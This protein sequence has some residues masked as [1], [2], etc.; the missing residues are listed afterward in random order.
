MATLESLRR[1]VYDA[2]EDWN[3][4][5]DPLLINQLLNRAQNVFSRDSGYL[6]GVNVQN[7]VAGTAL[8]TLTPPSNYRIGRVDAVQFHDGNGAI[9]SISVS[10]GGSLYTSSPT[11]TIAAPT[12]GTTATA[13][14]TASGGAV[15]A[16][17]L[18][19]AGTGYVGAPAISFS[20]G[21]GSGATAWATMAGIDDVPLI[22]LTLAEMNNLDSNWRVRTGQR[23]SYYLRNYDDATA[24]TARNESFRLYPLP[25]TNYTVG[26]RVS[27]RL[28][29]AGQMTT[30]STVMAL[31]ERI[32]EDAL[33]NYAAGQILK[34]MSL[35]DPRRSRFLT[36]ESDRYMALWLKDLQEA[37]AEVQT[38]YDHKPSRTRAYWV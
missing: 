24:S 23:P 13:T 31:P 21:G 9:G 11:V 33:V 12:S 8:Y 10:A 7:V 18:V 27:H 26:L 22:S 37:G 14:A 29:T 17:T 3:Q 25:N 4:R 19:L 16:V 38:G 28:V 32:A 34:R 15:T 6:R 36:E 30:D 5:R 1:R 2:L 35:E 20:G